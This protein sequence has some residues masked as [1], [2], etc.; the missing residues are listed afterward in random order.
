M[1]VLDCTMLIYLGLVAVGMGNTFLFIFWSSRTHI[2]SEIFA[3]IGAMIFLITLNFA[4]NV[5]VRYIRLAGDEQLFLDIVNSWY[6]GVR[7]A[8]LLVVTTYL[9]FRMLCRV[10]QTMKHAKSKKLWNDH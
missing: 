4:A 8:P 5:I 1:N 2:V 10:C 7:A 6:W 3:I 9:F